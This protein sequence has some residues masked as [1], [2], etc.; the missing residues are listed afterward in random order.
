M[1]ADSLSSDWEVELRALMLEFLAGGDASVPAG[2]DKFEGR[3]RRVPLFLP[4]ERD[5]PGKAGLAE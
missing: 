5:D 4:F 3:Q 2:Q 1:F